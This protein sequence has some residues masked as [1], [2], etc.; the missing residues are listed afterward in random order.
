MPR[1]EALPHEPPAP[2][3]L[4]SVAAAC[5]ADPRPLVEMVRR[6][7][8]EH[9]RRGARSLHLVASHNHLSPTAKA[10]LSSAVADNIASGR[11]GARDHAGA[12]WIDALDTVVVELSKRLFGA[13]WAEYRPMSGALANGLALL[14]LVAPGETVMALP[15]REGGHRTYRESG[16]AGVLRLK[17]V[18]VPYDEAA[19]EIDLGRLVDAA[20]AC[21]PRLI[22]VGTAELRFP[23]PVE[24]LAEIA[25]SVD[26]RLFYDGAHVMGLIAGGRFQDP[27]AEGAALLT[28]S[29][30]KTLA[31]PI[32]GLILTQ[33]AE[34]GAGISR[35]TSGLVSNYHN[36]RVAALAVTLAEMAAFGR[37]YA[38]QVVANAQA[39]GAALRDEGLPVVTYPRGLTESHIVLVDATKL[40]DPGGAFGALE[41]AG[42]LTTRVPLP[43]TYPDRL[44]IRLGTPAVTRQGMQA[45]EMA[46][47]ARLIRRTLL[48]REPPGWVAREVEELTGA[49]QGVHYCFDPM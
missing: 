27:L 20:A 9:G 32:G 11:L 31:G 41:A 12:G 18:D 37:A 42:I 14:A 28:G 16:Y 49:F 33:D 46:S 8:D 48:D 10:M 39:L 25:A 15:A 6:F 3:D 26:A 2:P 7:V 34:L 23:Y 19:D 30:Q 13:A 22:I 24:A 45:G 43:H 29:T 40:S 44:G 4:A 38:A 47:I 17:V 35:S 36:N 21:R 1:T 5:G